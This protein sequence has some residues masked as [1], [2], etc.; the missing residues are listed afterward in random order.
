MS[1][2][3]FVTWSGNL[4]I[5]HKLMLSGSLAVA[6]MILM[7]G[8]NVRSSSTIATDVVTMAMS[9]K[10]TRDQVDADMRHDAIARDVMAALLSARLGDDAKRID[11][12]KRL[13][14]NLLEF[15]DLVSGN[16]D[17]PLPDNVKKILATTM[18][19]LDAYGAE[20]KALASTSKTETADLIKGIAAFDASYDQLAEAMEAS[21]EAIEAFGSSVTDVVIAET[22]QSVFNGVLIALLG[23]VGLVAVFFLLSRALVAPLTSMMQ[24]MKEYAQQQFSLDVP[25]LSRQDEIGDMARTVDVF[26]RNGLENAELRAAQERDRAQSE[27]QKSQAL[28]QMA[29]K[30]EVETRDA[31]ER[32]AEQTG[33]VDREADAMARSARAVSE[34]A[35]AAAAAAQQALQNAEAVAAAAE[36]L[37]ASI[38]EIASQVTRATTVTAGAVEQ[39]RT[40][41][42]TI[43]N[44]GS[45]VEKIGDVTR[46]IAD[47]ASQTNL[48]A[49][50]ATIEAARAGEMGKGFAVVAAE[51]KNLATQT[52]KATDEIATLVS[53]IQNATR[54]AVQ[55]VRT[56]GQVVREVDEVSSG[57]A[58]AVEEQGAATTEISRNVIQAADA[59]REVSTRI[60]R[61]SSEAQ[62]TGE[63]AGS[64]R[65]SV[66]AVSSSINDL[67]QIL[68]RVVRTATTEVDRR[69]EPRLPVDQDFNI[70]LNGQSSRVRV[71]D[72]S[73]G[74]ARLVDFKARENA[75]GEI[76]FGDGSV[77]RFTVV[78]QRADGA[79][80]RFLDRDVAAVERLVRQAGGTKAKAA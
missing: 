27:L 14:E 51:V 12:L 18:V 32:V 58:A 78:Q 4:R 36:Q 38:Q 34:N 69:G 54:V 1:A 66:S 79:S 28:Q 44:L 47:I 19:R 10:A 29:E 52:G 39:G 30:V 80:I 16:L 70:R 49:L 50:N 64:V 11:A 13:D 33:S 15:R 59:S 41:E 22:D 24:V 23:S 26:R 40:A 68:V 56:M 53:E 75:S 2:M 21:A 9:A 48:L 6:L 72:I 3:N 61:V 5:P 7:A 55:S 65:S 42:G 74:G 76:V 63:R 71:A 77:V 31:V 60:A 20:A 25:G 57:V 43:G 8:L 62:A 37:A 67:Q 35:T 73:R 17:K 46:L 45:A